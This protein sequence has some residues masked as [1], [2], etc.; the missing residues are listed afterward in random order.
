MEIDIDKAELRKWGIIY[1]II[2]GVLLSAFS[3]ISFYVMISTSSVIV[4]SSAPFVFS[5]LLPIGAVV[6]LVINLRKKIGGFW[7]MRQAASGIFIMFFTA[8]VLQF[9]VRDMLFAKV[10][11]PNMVQKTQTAMTKAVSTYLTENK[12]K[13]DEVK[14]KM[15]DINQQFEVQKDVTV[16]R[17]ITGFG[18][19]II[20]MFVLSLIF[21]AFFKRE[22]VVYN[23]QP[24]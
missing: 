3:I 7:S 6:L 21:A 5:V 1:G 9:L 17:Q 19:S 22:G 16:G 24:Q 15:D 10:V 20:F 2:L 8:F 4:I 14:K 18:I 13:P 23:N 12:A 11:E